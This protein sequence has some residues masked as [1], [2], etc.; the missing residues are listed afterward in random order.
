M[1]IAVFL[2]MALAANAASTAEPSSWAPA[3]EESALPGTNGID[4]TLLRL[5]LEGSELHPSLVTRQLDAEPVRHVPRSVLRSNPQQST[6]AAFVK[7]IASSGSQ[8]KLGTQ[9]IRSALYALYR[10]DRDLGLYGLEAETEAD[11]ERMEEALRK[12]WAHNVSIE[13]A[14]IHRGGLAVVVV[15]TDGVPAE[16]WKEANSVVRERLAAP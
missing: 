2:V 16:I 10:G 4:S 9:G 5:V 13:R 11:A 12:I 7:A 14:R 8:G 3:G 6:D 15:W 1:R